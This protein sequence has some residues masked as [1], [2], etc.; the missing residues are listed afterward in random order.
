MVNSAVVRKER[1][2]AEKLRFISRII[3]IIIIIKMALTILIVFS[4][5]VVLSSTF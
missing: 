2:V 3:I 1:N 4:V 5:K